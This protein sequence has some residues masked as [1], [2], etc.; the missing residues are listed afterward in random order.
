MQMLSASSKKKY[1]MKA[2]TIYF[3]GDQFGIPGE[4]SDSHGGFGEY[5]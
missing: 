4:N 5:N 3:F 1:Q 2:K